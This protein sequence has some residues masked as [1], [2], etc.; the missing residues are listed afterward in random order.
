M[1]I[2]VYSP[3]LLNEAPNDLSLTLGRNQESP[4]NDGLE[5]AELIVDVDRKPIWSSGLL[6]L[7]ILR[8]SNYQVKFQ[9]HR[10]SRVRLRLYYQKQIK[11]FPVYSSQ[12]I[13]Y[14]VFG[15]IPGLRTMIVSGSGLGVSRAMGNLRSRVARQIKSS[16]SKPFGSKRSSNLRPSPET[17]NSQFLEVIEVGDLG[18]LRPAQSGRSVISRLS[19]QRSWTGTRTPGFG[20]KN[21]GRLPVNP[22]T[23]SIIEVLDDRYCKY[24][25]N[26]STG[27]HTLELTTYSQ[28]Y[29]VPG[30]EDY[31]PYQNIAHN[32]ALQRLISKANVGIQANFAQNL[33][34]LGQITSLVAGN[35]MKIRQSLRQL[36]RG[37][38]SGAVSAL[39]SGPGGPN[40]PVSGL[41]TSKS[42]ASN[43]LQLQYGWKPLLKDIENLST[44]F[45][46]LTSA[47]RQV[48]RVTG[49]GSAMNELTVAYPPGDQSIGLSNTGKTTHI[50]RHTVKLGV[51]YVIDD[52]ATAF[53]AQLGFTNPINLAWEVL[54]F[55][56]V[57]DWF[58]P[59]GS[60]LESHSAFHGYRFIDGFK[61][62]FTRVKMDSAISYS[63]PNQLNALTQM[64]FGA[65]YR[66]ERIILT[67]QAL[68]S[69][70]TSTFPTLTVNPFR[71]S[72]VSS[73]TNNRAAN[74]IALLVKAFR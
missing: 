70:P 55:S 43:W 17:I 42:L 50:S 7:N 56:F 63:G 4:L 21:I 30:Y 12:S 18:V 36:K 32:K 48:H 2:P 38:F 65:S 46:N 59:I 49:S 39:Q 29:F 1:S 15:P 57:V 51:S 24:S 31:T 3:Y 9:A 22:H 14:K 66:R 45:G 13:P 67:R 58:L 60:F 72:G 33:A 62:T 35:A 27:E 8:R 41:S 40:I 34:Q 26:P 47:G 16:S 68:T 64:N 69:F 73:G 23:V 25:V 61:T 74:A 28:R 6:R 71:N 54:P 10:S 19:Y 44:V 53:F 37:N 11:G 52:D 20:S 5:K